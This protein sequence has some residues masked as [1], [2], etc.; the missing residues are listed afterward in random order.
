[1]TR[2]CLRISVWRTRVLNYSSRTQGIRRFNL[3][4][5]GLLVGSRWA[6][7]RALAMEEADGYSWF[8]IGSHAEYDRLLRQ[9]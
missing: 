8:W 1:M 3:R 7:Y 6:A 5:E 2:C 4:K 9:N